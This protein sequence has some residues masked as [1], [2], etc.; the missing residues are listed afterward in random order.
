MQETRRNRIVIDLD[1]R[2]RAKTIS[3]EQKR[4]WPKVLATFGIIAIAVVVLTIAGIFI[5]WQ[6]Y[7]TTPAYSLALIVDAAQRKDVVALNNMLDTEKIAGNMAGQV[8]EKAVARYGEALTPA[9][10]KSV[11]VLIPGLMPRVRQDIERELARTVEQFA[12]QSGRRPFF[13]IA[14]MMPYVVNINT[15]GDVAKVTSTVRN[16]PTELTLERYADQW[17]ITSV[18]D[19][20]IVQRVVDRVLQDLPAIGAPPGEPPGRDPFRLP[21]RRRRSR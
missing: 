9:A 15:Q 10:R 7:K 6:R 4:R 13:V 14:V 3:R 21:R 5:W 19:E 1:P 8:T 18:T 17:K 20:A 11:E 12:E 2:Q 16:R